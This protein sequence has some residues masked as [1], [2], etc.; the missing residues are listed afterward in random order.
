MRVARAVVVL[1]A[2]WLPAA[3]A[4]ATWSIVAVDPETREVGIAGASCIGGVEIIGGLVPGRGAVAAQASANLAGRD[5]AMDRLAAGS[6]PVPKQG[7]PAENPV[8]KLR[9]RTLEALGGTACL[10][11][12]ASGSYRPVP[13]T[14]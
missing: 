3:P 8:R 10:F 14:P 2:V 6:S 7:G 4:S 12:A 9:A 5:L 11:D 13:G 1:S